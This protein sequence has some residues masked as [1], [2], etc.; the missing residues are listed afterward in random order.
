M[1]GRVD[2]LTTA[3]SSLTIAGSTPSTTKT[4]TLRRRVSIRDK[5]RQVRLGIK[6]ISRPKLTGRGSKGSLAGKRAIRDAVEDVIED[7]LRATQPRPCCEEDLDKVFISRRLGQQKAVL[8][9]TFETKAE[10]RDIVSQGQKPKVHGVLSKMPLLGKLDVIVLGRVAK[11]TVVGSSQGKTNPH[12][13]EHD[14]GNYLLTNGGFFVTAPKAHEKRPC[15]LKVD[16]DGDRF[17]QEECKFYSVGPASSWPN[18]FPIPSSQGQYYQE[19]KGEDGTF[20]SAGPTIKEPLDLSRRELKWEPPYCNVVIGGV[21][22]SGDPN[23]R[24]V[25]VILPDGT[26]IIFVYT[27]ANRF[28]YGCDMNKMRGII[29]TF[30]QTYYKTP[31]AKTQMALNLDGGSSIYVSWKER[32]RRPRL[33]AVGSLETKVPLRLKHP[34]RVTNLIKFIV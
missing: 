18:F 22:T 5:T 24:L 30:L 19:I 4:R 10:W 16:W 20:L 1:C 14:D 9:Y 34:K 7:Y 11:T 33:I 8:H 15:T 17:D 6:A 25:H 12:E 32:G 28:L 27:C 23:E 31:I 3:F 21:H 2:S 26:K 29:D 13:Y